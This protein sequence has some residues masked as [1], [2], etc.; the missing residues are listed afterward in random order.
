MLYCRPPALCAESAGDHTGGECRRRKH[1]H[2]LEHWEYGSGT[3]FRWRTPTRT[4]RSRRL[5]RTMW[6]RARTHDPAS[7]PNAPCSGKPADW[8]FYTFSG[9]QQT[10]GEDLQSVVLNPGFNNPA[11]PA[12]DYSLPNRSPGVGFV[13]LI[14]VRRDGPTRFSCLQRSPP[15]S[16]PSCSIQL[17]IIKG[18]TVSDP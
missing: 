12:D 18:Y 4:S 8:T 7:G 1:D 15:H 16:R 11:Y 5:S 3:S 2:P 9:W 13:C 14:P 10:V 17:R 6:W